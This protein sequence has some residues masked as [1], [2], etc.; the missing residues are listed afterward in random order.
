MHKY[1]RT[2]SFA[3]IIV[4]S[5]GEPAKDSQPQFTLGLSLLD[6][7]RGHEDLTRFAVSIANRRI[8]EKLG[9]NEYYTRIPFGENGGRSTLPM[10]KGSFDTDW[11]ITMVSGERSGESLIN[12][13]G[14]AWLDSGMAWQEFPWLQSLHFLRD[15]DAAGQVY[16]L[17]ES[18]ASGRERISKA[19][20]QSILTA[21]KREVS[22]YWLGHVLHIVQDSFSKAHTVR[23]PDFKTILNICTFGEGSAS[24]ACKHPEPLSFEGEHPIT[25]ALLHDDRVWIAGSTA[26]DGPDERD[27]S[28]LKPEAQKA[29]EVSAGVLYLYAEIVGNGI[30]APRTEGFEEIASFMTG[31]DRWQGGYFIGSWEE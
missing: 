21:R 18:L 30:A 22:H 19:F 31:Q 16:S 6:V 8:K 9:L 4:A 27:W 24:D 26:C 5:C 20:Q 1:L 15:R 2:L 7:T 3:S 12:F 10:I 23:S 11:A 13:Y 29:A 14:V 28:C 17:E 25:G